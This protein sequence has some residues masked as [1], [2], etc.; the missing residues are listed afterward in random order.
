VLAVGPLRARFEPA[1][2][3][4]RDLRW[5]EAPALMAIYAAVRD[6]NWGTV[7]TQVRGLAVQRSEAGLSLCFEAVCT[8]ADIDFR[9]HGTITLSAAGRLRWDF[10]GRALATFRR[11]RIGFCILHGAAECAGRPCRVTHSDSRASEGCFPRAIAPRQPFLDIRTVTHALAN[12]ATCQVTCDGEVF[13][14]E[15]QRNWSDASFKTY[16]TPLAQPFPVTIAAGTRVRQSVEVR[17]SPPTRPPRRRSRRQGPGRLAPVGRSATGWPAVGHGL[18]ERVLDPAEIALV[19]DLL[20]PDFVRVPVDPGVAGWEGSLAQARDL[21][22]R[23]ATGI[24][25][26]LTLPP[27]AAAGLR[28]VR[29]A[30]ARP[31]APVRRWLVLPPGAACTPPGWAPVAREVLA[32]LFPLAGFGV[33]TRGNFAELNRARPSPAAAGVVAYALAVE[34]HASDPQSILENAE[35]AQWTVQAAR[36]LYPGRAIAVGPVAFRQQLNP[37]ATAATTPA[38]PGLLPDPVDPRQGSLFGA[39]FALGVAGALSLGGSHSVTLFDLAGMTG[40]LEPRAAPSRPPEFPWARGAVYPLFHV[41]ADLRAAAGAPLRR[42]RI[43]GCP[44]APGFEFRGP[45]GRRILVANPGSDPL[46]VHLPETAGHWRCRVLSEDVL[47]EA[48]A[49]PREFRQPQRLTVARGPGLELP[50]WAYA[51]LIEEGVEG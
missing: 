15:D 35:A 5:H 2:G 25:V 42:C 26:V 27:D 21:A 11:N 20:R 51:C 34:V 6:R 22:A 23:L 49:E 40:V 12:G 50:P 30:L 38:A 31:S 24:E 48:L 43:A 17:L 7:P 14:M 16:C 4:L 18:G 44:T 8:Q 36:R 13:E 37:V 33:G 28:Q 29:E 45:G 39:A 32:R 46:R 41:L 9:W 1:T 3:M 47:P 10:D 19:R